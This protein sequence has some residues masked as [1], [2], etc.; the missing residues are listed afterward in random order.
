VRPDPKPEAKEDATNTGNLE[1]VNDGL[2]EEDEFDEVADRFESTYN[3][4][5]EEP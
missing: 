1:E 5:F 2:L 4:R 3:F